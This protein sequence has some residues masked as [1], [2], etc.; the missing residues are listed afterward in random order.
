MKTLSKEEQIA[1]AH[2]FSMPTEDA[3][4]EADTFFR[5]RKFTK[6]EIESALTQLDSD[7]GKREFIQYVLLNYQLPNVCFAPILAK[8]FE[9]A[10]LF[11]A[12]KIESK[13][14]QSI[15]DILLACNLYGVTNKHHIAYILATAKGEN[16]FTPIDE[17][18]S[19]RYKFEPNQTSG[20]AT[21][22]AGNGNIPCG[23]S[24]V[25]RGY[26]PKDKPQIQKLY[27][28]NVWPA[29]HYKKQSAEFQGGVQ[30][31][32]FNKYAG[33]AYPQITFKNNYEKMDK[34]ID[35]NLVDNP[36]LALDPKNAAKILVIGMKNGMFTGKSLS[37][38]DRKDGT[39]NSLEARRIINGTDR[40]V[41]FSHFEATYF[42]NLQSPFH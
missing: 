29:S 12:S 10:A 35:G 15:A 7:V 27:N 41:K 8:R 23:D 22:N 26:I 34:Y 5:A 9:D 37:R 16:E 14:K 19:L 11:L 24:L 20:K 38:Y 4:T 6:V 31:C 17:I 32:D 3:L 33:R 40:K 36:A 21:Y 1:L 13:K 42:K 30:S 28:G 2:I 39:F 25:A 18:G